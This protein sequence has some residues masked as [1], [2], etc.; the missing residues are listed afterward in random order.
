MQ[1]EPPEIK[2]NN[3]IES[4]ITAFKPEQSPPLD[5][6]G[7]CILTVTNREILSHMNLNDLKDA[8]HYIK[9]K[10]D[11]FIYIYDN[12]N[13]QNYPDNSNKYSKKCLLTAMLQAKKLYSTPTGGRRKSRRHRKTKVSQKSKKTRRT[14]NSRK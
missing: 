8:F 2:I 6:D 3:F 12:D 14:R 4:F 11:S 5:I 1:S 7:T 9:K 10:D 13:S